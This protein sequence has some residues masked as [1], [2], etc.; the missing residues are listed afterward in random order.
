MRKWKMLIT[1]EYEDSEKNL[2]G[3][4]TI[5]STKIKHQAHL[6]GVRGWVE[7]KETSLSQ[8]QLE[9]LSSCLQEIT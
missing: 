3:R 5:I 4:Y 6:G 9:S 8:D 2:P 1:I 7:Q